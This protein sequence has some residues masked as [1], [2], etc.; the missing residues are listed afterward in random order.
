[1]KLKVFIGSS[2]EHL[3]LARAVQ[4]NLDPD[5]E[6]K[7]WDQDVFRMSEYTLEA[8]AT[9]L[10]Q[11]DFGVFVMEPADWAVIHGI[12]HPVPRDNVVFELGLFV[13]HLGRNR[14]FVIIPRGSLGLHLPTDLLGLTV[15]DYDAN[16]TDKSLT[17]AFAPVCNKIR[18]LV[19]ERSTT[20]LKQRTGLVR[21]GL[22]TDFIEDFN[23]LL[24]ESKE[25]VLYFIHSRR[26]RE[27]HNDA[28]RTLLTKPKSSLT[29]FL[30]DL[31]NKQLVTGLTGHF[32]DGPHIPGFIAD[33]Y[34]YFA[35]LQREYPGKV[36]ILLFND[37]PTYTF[38]R[39]DD[40][41][42]AAMYP[43]TA[44]RKSVPAFYL[45]MDGTF[46][47]FLDK[48]IEQLFVECKE[49]SAS[50]LLQI[51]SAA[52]SYSKGIAGEQII[53]KK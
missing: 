12:K 1:M 10:Q 20:I 15:G 32:D 51:G 24:N 17:A 18:R 53:N 13:G 44:I 3:D 29:V 39:F 31:A 43:T 26:W 11:S 22:F 48:D 16:R 46:G 52:S 30:P 35:D 45:K 40:A 27:N 4:E 49:P 28:I 19:V 8:L 47:E 14:T 25:V 34:R 50:G 41:V 9:Q 42:I 38:Y 5:L 23:R 6:T 33:A 21:F 36:R 7:V 2:K 37:Y